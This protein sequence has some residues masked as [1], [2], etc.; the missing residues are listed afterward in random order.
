VLL[1]GGVTLSVLVVVVFE[2]SSACD[3][4]DDK[5]KDMETLHRGDL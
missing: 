1:N 5:D 2:N 4:V 3:M